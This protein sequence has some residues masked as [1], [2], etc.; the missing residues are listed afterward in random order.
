MSEGRVEVTFVVDYLAAG[1]AERHAVTLASGLDL[2]RFE[3]SFLQ[4]KPGGALEALLDKPRL[5]RFECVDVARKLDYDAVARFA[6][7]LE[8]TRC[9]VIVAANPYATLYSILASRRLPAGSRPSV[10]STFHSTILRGMKNQLQM[11]FYR[12][13]YPF[14]DV[15]VYVCENQRIHWRRRALRARSEAMIY[16]GIDTAYF[17][18][19]A[20]E[21]RREATR[22]KLGFADT[23]FV[24]GIC[25][26]LRPEKAHGDLLEAMARLKSVDRTVRCLVIGDG[27]ERQVL[28]G[29]IRSLGIADRVVITGYEM[30]VRPYVAACDVMVLTSHS[31]TF[32]LSALESM[33]MGKPMLMTLTGGAAEQVTDGVTGFLFEPGDVAA[34]ANQL[35]SMAASTRS[36]PMGAAAAQDVAR[37]F[38][39]AKMVAE[40]SALF[41]AQAA[42]AALSGPRRA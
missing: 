35:A 17:S 33:A 16:N 24:V 23:D 32:S 25:A 29:R 4:L 14:C 11:A 18:S 3:V 9:R 1:G 20:A 22:C 8:E 36:A 12:L 34:L 41:E 39:L 26:A 7:H 40:Y 5:A 38:P 42:A 30:D 10:V 15:L 2:S 31:E 19:A 13:M 28:E 6:R 21:S 37:R 27:P